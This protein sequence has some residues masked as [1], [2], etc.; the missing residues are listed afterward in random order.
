MW[1]SFKADSSPPSSIPDVDVDVTV[2]EPVPLGGP[3]EGDSLVLQSEAVRLVRLAIRKLEDRPKS[4]PSQLPPTKLQSILQ[5]PPAA[6]RRFSADIS[7]AMRRGCG[8]CSRSRSSLAVNEFY[9]LSSAEEDNNEL[10]VPGRSSRSVSVGSAAGNEL[11]LNVPN[12][13]SASTSPTPSVG[14]HSNGSL[15]FVSSC[16]L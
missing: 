6:I 3:S 11:T 7:S 9:D 16:F 5:I 2:D 10:Q 4:S 13:H 8:N 14:A 1:R 12:T 15:Y